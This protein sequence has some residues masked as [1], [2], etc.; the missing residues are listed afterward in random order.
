MPIDREKALGYE[1]P[2]GEGHYTRDDVILYPNVVIYE[3]AVL[4]N[5]VT[6]HAGTV[7]G[8]DGFGYATHNGE[9]HK[10]PQTGIVVIEDAVEMGAGCAID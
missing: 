8:Q 6:L 3:G 4:G 5:R 10:I 7:I 2:G 9:H 1:F